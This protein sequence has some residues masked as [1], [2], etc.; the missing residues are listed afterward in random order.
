RDSCFE[1]CGAGA[2]IVAEEGVGIDGD[3][4]E[5]AAGDAAVAVDAAAA[6]GARIVIVAEEVVLND[7]GVGGAGV[8]QEKAGDVVLDN[9][10]EDAGAGLAGG[11]DD[12]CAIAALAGVA[13]DGKSIEGDVAGGDVEPGAR[14]A[15]KVRPDDDGLV[16]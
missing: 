12:A 3:V 10:V 9:V 7:R 4:G 2:A 1:G 6:V 16:R 13:L 8:G 14:D 15:A 5:I 11:D